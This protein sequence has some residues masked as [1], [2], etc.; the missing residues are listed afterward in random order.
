VAARHGLDRRGAY[1]LITIAKVSAILCPMGHTT[2][3]ERQA[4]QLGTMLEDPPLLRRVYKDA[5]KTAWGTDPTAAQVQ[6]AAMAIAN[7]NQRK[8]LAA[9]PE[10][11][12][13]SRAWPA[14][15]PEPPPRDV[16]GSAAAAGSGTTPD[17]R[18]DAHHAAGEHQDQAEAPPPASPE[19]QVRAIPTSI[20]FVNP[21]KTSK[22]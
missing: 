4:R 14:T 16:P 20:Q 19:D 9:K 11:E 3:S 13:P 18:A 6:Q 10:P 5:R 15:E 21:P 12:P 2:A 7:A 1:R 17:T 22:E 8:E